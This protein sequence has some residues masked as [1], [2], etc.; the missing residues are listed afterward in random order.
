MQLARALLAAIATDRFY[1]WLPETKVAFINGFIVVLYNY[2]TMSK[3]DR[4]Q[5]EFVLEGRFLGF[6]AKDSYK[7]KYLRLA[8]NAS[9]YFIKIPKELRLTLYRTLAAGDWVYVSGYQSFCPKKGT[10]KFKAYDIRP[11]AAPSMASESTGTAPIAVLPPVERNTAKKTNI[12]VCQKSDCCKRG[13]RALVAALQA[14]LD[15]RGM[16]DQVAIKGTGCMKH[17]KAGPNLVMP[18]KT[19]YSRIQ[20]DDVSALLD[21]HFPAPTSELAATPEAMPVTTGVA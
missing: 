11:I 20:A 13:G 18:D 6:A 8:A 9:E 19:R 1:I 3:S 21:K 4:H 15:D 12:L 17:C 5:T 16:S 14:E 10:V 2:S 7:L